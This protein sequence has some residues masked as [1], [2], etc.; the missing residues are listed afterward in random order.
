MSPK[1]KTPVPPPPGAELLRVE[2]VAHVLD[3]SVATVYREIAD[4]RLAVRKIRDRTRI[5]RDD[6]DAY[7]RAARQQQRPEAVA[8]PPTPA[9][10]SLRE[11][12][13]ID[14][15]DFAPK[16]RRPAH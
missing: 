7:L 1:T 11:A 15:D 12:G 10:I 13:L 5:H 8:M 14:D 6:L 9:R 4:G 2:H 3:V 16:R